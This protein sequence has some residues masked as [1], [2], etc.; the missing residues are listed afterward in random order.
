MSDS[1][2]FGSGEFKIISK[3]I[4]TD[5]TIRYTMNYTAKHPGDDKKMARGKIS[6]GGKT[7]ELVN[8]DVGGFTHYKHPNVIDKDHMSYRIYRL[9]GRE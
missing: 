9:V 5:G 1:D 2:A 4:D 8:I 7:W 6:D 3:R